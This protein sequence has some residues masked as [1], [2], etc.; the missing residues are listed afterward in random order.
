MFL[1]MLRWSRLQLITRGAGLHAICS[2]RSHTG[3]SMGPYGVRLHT[4]AT[5][6]PY[7]MLQYV[8]CMSSQD[9]G[10]EYNFLLNGT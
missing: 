9:F 1:D 8:T 6:L 7:M 10:G 4:V 3:N 5:V 2:L